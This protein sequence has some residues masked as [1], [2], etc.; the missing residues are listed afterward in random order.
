MF[1]I[2]IDA[3]MPIN[4]YQ[5]HKIISLNCVCIAAYQSHRLRRLSLP[6]NRAP[7]TFT[8]FCVLY[9]NLK[10]SVMAPKQFTLK[11]KFIE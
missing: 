10:T 1:S 11:L 6:V 5:L 4:S 9:T 8:F 2:T 7:S 3:P